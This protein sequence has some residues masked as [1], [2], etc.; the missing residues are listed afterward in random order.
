MFFCVFIL[1]LRE[2]IRGDVPV[3]K[4]ISNGAVCNDGWISNSHGQGTCSH[5][6]GVDYYLYKEIQTG[7]DYANPTPYYVI[8]FCLMGLIVI[9]SLFNSGYRWASIKRIA[10]VLYWSLFIIQRIFVIAFYLPFIILVLIYQVY[11]RPVFIF[12]TKFNKKN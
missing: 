10:D 1:A 6:G 11:L 2:G 9:P 4:K 5:H 8:T 12:I 3:F 7:I